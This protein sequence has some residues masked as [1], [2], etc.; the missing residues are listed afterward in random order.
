MKDVHAHGVA[1]DDERSTTDA[2][3]LASG[4]AKEEQERDEK[5]CVPPDERQAN[6]A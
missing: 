6:D 3:K 5:T 4:V 2:E 1:D